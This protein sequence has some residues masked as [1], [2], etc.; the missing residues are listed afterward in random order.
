MSGYTNG[1]LEIKSEYRDCYYIIQTKMQSEKKLPKTL[2]ALA[3]KLGVKDMTTF[4]KIPSKK[5]N[6][7]LAANFSYTEDGIPGL[8]RVYV[9]KK[10]IYS[11][12]AYGQDLSLA[13][14]FFDSVVF[15]KG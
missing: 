2:K 10:K 15:K 5:K 6:V 4:R 9:T 1:L 14:D 7:H 13:N 11:F 12:M 3:K 8:T